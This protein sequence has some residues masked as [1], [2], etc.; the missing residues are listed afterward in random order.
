M[1]ITCLTF[2]LLFYIIIPTF[3]FMFPGEISET[4]KLYVISE[5]ARTFIV[6]QIVIVSVDLPY[7]IWKNK[8]VKALSDQRV[9]F[10]NN[11]QMLHKLVEC[12]DYPL[13]IRL[14]VLFRIWSLVLFYAFF[15]PY[16][17]FYILIAFC[18]IFWVE[19][20]NLYKHYTIRRRVSIK[21]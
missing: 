10:R 14:Q 7:R 3:F 11:Q 16:M 2:H 21:L 19:K 1:L 4:V 17:T 9:A 8:K 13:E 18:I 20:N 6:V 15:I 12:R 5:Q